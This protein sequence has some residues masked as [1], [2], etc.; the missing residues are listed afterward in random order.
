VLSQPC[1]FRNYPFS[2]LCVSFEVVVWPTLVIMCVC[3]SYGRCKSACFIV[4]SWCC[5][6]RCWLVG[7]VTHQSGLPGV[8]RSAV[9]SV[10][11]A[12]PIILIQLQEQAVVDM[13]A[14]PV[15]CVALPLLR[16]VTEN[17]V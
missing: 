14:H 10:E 13:R 12:A 11:V 6:V 4:A 9:A 15:V 17:V 16:R 2:C 5:C 1:E 3:S 7:C 8:R